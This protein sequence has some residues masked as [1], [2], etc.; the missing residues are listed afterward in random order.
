V[1]GNR[2]IHHKVRLGCRPA[3]AFR[4]FTR[5]ELL[6][7]WLT[8]RARVEPRLGG[9]YELFWSPEH[10]E[11]DSTV[12]CRITAFVPNR[13]LAFEWKGPKQYRRFMNRADPLTQVTVAFFPHASGKGTEIHLIHTGWRDTRLW[14]EARLWFDRSWAFCLKKALVRCTVPKRPQP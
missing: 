2:I 6:E 7:R 14:E 5:A 11:F 8:V 4:F 9:R 12:G 13:L 3:G 10:P 1:T